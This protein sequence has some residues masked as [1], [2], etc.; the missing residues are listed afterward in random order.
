MIKMYLEELVIHNFRGFKDYTL[1]LKPFNVLIGENYSGK[2]S[3]LQAIQLVYESI[4]VLFE[5]GEHPRFTGISWQVN[6]EQPISR[7]GLSATELIFFKKVPAGLRIS[8]KWSNGLQLNFSTV[9]KTAFNFELFENGTSIADKLND[10]RV[11]ELITSVYSSKVIMLPPVGTISPNETFIARPQMDTQQAQGRYNET[12]RGNLF[13]RYNSGDKTAFDDLYEFIRTYIPNSNVRPP[14]LSEDN[15]P[16]FVIE[17]EEDSN[18]Y[19]ISSSGGGLRT[20]ISIAAILKLTRASCILLDEPDTH[21]H[22]KL[23]RDM[24]E[25]LWEHSESQNIQMMIATHSPDIIDSVP[26]DSLLFIDRLMSEA[27]PVDNVGNALVSLGA[28]TNSQAV[29]ATGAKSIINIEGRGDKIVFPECAKKSEIEFLGVPDARLIASGKKNLKELKHIHNGLLD[30]LKVDMKIVAINDLDYDSIAQEME[31]IKEERETGV[32]L[33]TLGKKEIENYLLDA[34][35]ITKAVK[36]R[37]EKRGQNYE[38]YPS[39]ERVI[40]EMI[41]ECLERYKNDLSWKIRPLIRDELKNNNRGWGDSTLEEETDKKFEKLWEKEAWRLSACP[42]K[43]VLKDIR[44]EIQKK[45]GVSVSNRLLCQT[46]DSVPDDI[47]SVFT[48]LKDFLEG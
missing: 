17:Y 4:Q 18:I 41:I 3:V 44:T 8:A 42:G 37:L 16:K 15:P 45:W 23:Q 1:K 38:D 7:L 33:L 25:I 35:A 31:G 46:L 28:L 14:R 5:G 29:A 10:P 24:A 12:W 32:L 19:D 27:V 47:Q 13:W 39:I 9:H 11:Q 6:L 21:L 43:A 2:T 30:F 48:K 40:R 26:L 36:G 34:N 22:S 20:L